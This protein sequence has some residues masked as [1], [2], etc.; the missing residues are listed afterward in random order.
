MKKTLINILALSL[1]ITGCNEKKEQ[2]VP[3]TQTDPQIVLIKTDFKN[4]KNWKADNLS[5]I[6]SGFALSCEK[7]LKEKNEYLSNAKIQ[8]P[9]EKYQKICLDYL[10]KRPQTTEEFRHFA[11]QNF[12]PYLVTD[13]GNPN[14]KFTSYYEAAIRASKNKSEKYKYPI[15]GKPHDLIEFNIK[16]FDPNA[17]SK[18]F[19]GRIEGQKLVPYYTREEI[20]QKPINAPIILWGDCNIDVNIMQIQGSA[21]A[22]LDNGEKLRVGYAGNNGHPFRGLGS[23]LLSKGLLEKGKSSMIEIKKW[24]KENQD[25]ADSIYNENKRYIFHR[26]IEN[27]DGPLGAQGVPLHAGRSMAVDKRYIPLGA[28]LWLETKGPDNEQIEKLVVAQDI[29]SA[30]KGIVRGDYFWGSGGDDVLAK[31][32]RMHSDGQYYILLPKEYEQQEQKQ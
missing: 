4:L 18:K 25:K 2:Q 11:E 21:V 3:K 15:Y 5:E 22:W 7:I 14:G 24:L 1:I 13:K 32:G 6:I 19:I 8:I 17:D 9:T 23:I 30:I 16:D 27:S 10:S 26:I 12:T 31:A 28:M 29:G 20:K